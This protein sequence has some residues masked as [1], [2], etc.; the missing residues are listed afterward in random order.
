M[1]V[2]LV[3]YTG[4]GIITHLRN[5]LYESIMGRSVAFFQRHTTGTIISTLI[6]DIDRVQNAMSNVLSE[7][8]QQT[9]TLIFTAIVV[10]ALGGKLEGL[11]HDP[12]SI[13]N[14]LGLRS[15]PGVSG[16]LPRFSYFGILRTPPHDESTQ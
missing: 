14:A 1:L 9:F 3:N 10:V 11:G 4:F 15:I 6:N 7:F 5:D 2:H 12:D 13:A 16:L 8:L